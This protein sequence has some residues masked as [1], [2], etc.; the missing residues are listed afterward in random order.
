MSQRWRELLASLLV[1]PWFCRLIWP[2]MT[3]IAVFY[4]HGL[5]RLMRSLDPERV[6]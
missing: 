4:A 3:S 6:L 5:R 1:T 2:L